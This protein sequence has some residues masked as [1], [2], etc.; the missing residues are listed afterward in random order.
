ML[1]ALHHAANRARS[2]GLEAARQLIENNKLVDD[3]DFQNALAAILE[4]LPVS[5]TFTGFEAEKGDVAEAAQDFDVLENIRRLL[6]SEKVPQAKQLE[7][8]LKL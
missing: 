2:N 8:W 6:F 4:V 7:L 5:S 3:L 1:D